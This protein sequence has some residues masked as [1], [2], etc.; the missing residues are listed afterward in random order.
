MAFTDE[1]SGTDQ[2]AQRRVAL[3]NL[4]DGPPF[5][6]ELSAGS[7]KFIGRFV[8]LPELRT[9]DYVIRF[10]DPEPASQSTQG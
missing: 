6:V 10:R 1:I 5:S 7:E 9:R 8:R 3:F 2:P 4:V